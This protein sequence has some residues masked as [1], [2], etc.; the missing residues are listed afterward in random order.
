MMNLKTKKSLKVVVLVTIVCTFAIV[1]AIVIPIVASKVK[2]NNIQ[3]ESTLVEDKTSEMDMKPVSNDLIS[4]L[5]GNITFASGDIRTGTSVGGIYNTYKQSPE[6]MPDL[7]EKIEFFSLRSENIFRCIYAKKEVCDAVENESSYYDLME[8]SVYPWRGL[9]AYFFGIRYDDTW[10][11]ELKNSQ[12]MEIDFNIEINQIKANVN[13]YYLLDIVRYYNDA[14]IE[15]F[16]FVDFV[17]YSKKNNEVLINFSE[18]KGSL[19][20]FSCTFTSPNKY[21]KQRDFTYLCLL[22]YHGV[23]I[24]QDDEAEI[25]KDVFRYSNK[26][27]P[28]YYDEID[29][30]IIEKKFIKTYAD[31]DYYE[32]IFNYDML[33]KLF[34]FFNNF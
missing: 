16:T 29:A 22:D 28:H 27:D 33:M 25:I 1:S 14:N 31:Y 2:S 32:A 19:K 7:A 11:D 21:N 9:T 5:L 12:L 4:S 6:K 34:G 15:N 23:E 8:N 18:S 17:S 30:C 24:V 26:T 20:Y 13:D 10:T 3:N